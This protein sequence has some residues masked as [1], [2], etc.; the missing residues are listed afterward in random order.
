MK[1]RGGLKA[2]CGLRSWIDELP[3]KGRYARHS[4]NGEPRVEAAAVVAGGA[5]RRK[6][7]Y[8]EACCLEK[9][10]EYQRQLDALELA[11]AKVIDLDCANRAQTEHID[12]QIIGDYG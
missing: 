7:Y 3:K 2:S 11:M 6:E 1:Q 8:N 10:N 5:R 12:Y 4:R 9:C